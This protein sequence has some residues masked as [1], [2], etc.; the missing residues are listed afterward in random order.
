MNDARG[1]R[2][3]SRLRALGLGC[4]AGL[5]VAEIALR[6]ATPLF[7]H[8]PTVDNDAELTI[9]C[10]GDSFTYGI[11]GR[12][13]PE[14]LEAMLEERLGTPVQAINAGVPGLNSA[15]LADELESHLQTWSPDVLIVLIGE[16]NSWNAVR[17]EPSGPLAALDRALLYSRV[18][19]FFRVAAVGWRYGTFHEAVEPGD[20]PGVGEVSE[21][22]GL[23]FPSGE[24]APDK[25][26]TPPVDAEGLARFFAVMDLVGEGRYAECVD[27]ASAFIATYPHAPQG[28]ATA[29]GCLM[30]L[31][32]LDEAAEVAG[33]GLATAELDDSFEELHFGHGNA[34]RRAGRHDEATA[35]FAAGLERFPASSPL[36]W[37][38]SEVFHEAGRTFEALELVDRHP[39]LA[40]NAIFVYLRKMES[41]HSVTELDAAVS[42]GLTA[43]MERIVDLGER[44]GARVILSSY[45]DVVYEEVRQVAE[46]RD[47][48]FVSLPPRF[49]A[50]FDSRDDYISA[51]RCHCNSE[52]YALIAEVFADVV[53]AGLVPPRAA[54]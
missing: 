22:I 30:R 34:L 7:Q 4:V 51:D 18:Y 17:T 50:R 27:A 20:H 24:F 54:P 45:P 8:Q 39:A 29:T 28:Y 11:G 53:S 23:E 41:Q 49:E 19:K 3:I 42:E 15:V 2:P 35:T 48:T 31:D 10:E 36:A 1:A 33:R 47:T 13:Y 6:V 5:M 37:A 14:Q 52:G 46:A 40:D 26:V 21:E 38:Y 9:L 44:Y 25:R 43:D 16:N 32:R 12:S